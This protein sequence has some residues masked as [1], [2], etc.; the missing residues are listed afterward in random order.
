MSVNYLQYFYTILTSGVLLISSLII[1]LEPYLPSFVKQHFLYGKL[2]SSPNEKKSKFLILVPKSNFR[3][4]YRLGG[5]IITIIFIVATKVYVYG[6]D[7]PSWFLFILDL[8]CGKNRETHVNGTKTY[9]AICLIMLQ[10]YRRLY[11]THFVSI[12]SKKAKMSLALFVVALLYYAFLPLALISEATRF[13]TFAH[14]KEYFELSQLSWIDFLAVLLFLWA[15]YHQ[16]VATKILANLRLDSTGKK[17]T[18]AHGLPKGDWFEYL[19][20]PH[21]IAEILMYFSVLI[22][23][24]NNVTFRIL[25]MFV[26]SNQVVSCLLTHRWYL[27]KFPEYPKSRKALIPF[28]Y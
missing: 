5:I 20:S 17:I 1:A 3:D 2:A 24:W 28:I 9:V 19:S 11:D 8:I 6:Q 14:T 23:I 10:V 18:E 7:P 13:S 27:E 15:W 22:I 4:F 25:F 21:Q 12:F 16:H 26:L